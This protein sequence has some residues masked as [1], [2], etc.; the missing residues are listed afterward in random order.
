[1]DRIRRIIRHEA[2]ADRDDTAIS[3]HRWQAA[4]LIWEELQTGTTM[5]ALGEAIGRSRQHVLYASRC[6]ELAGQSYDEGD[7][8]PFNTIY[9]S[10]EVRGSQHPPVIGDQ[11]AREQPITQDQVGPHTAHAWVEQA[12]EAV[13][14]LT[15][16]QA[17]WP[18]L[19]ANDIATLANLPNRIQAIVDQLAVSVPA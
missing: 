11:P 1:M 6:W 2:A 14:S 3:R 8:P 12:S 17:T 16:H 5:T 4:Q 10:V 19:D 9:H 7:L 13:R 15:E 18:F